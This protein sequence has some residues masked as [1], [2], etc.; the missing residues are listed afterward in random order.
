MRIVPGEQ[1]MPYLTDGILDI[2]EAQFGQ[3]AIQMFPATIDVIHG[4]QFYRGMMT[5]DQ[6]GLPDMMLENTSVKRPEYLA[7]G[8]DRRNAKRQEAAQ[9]CNKQHERRKS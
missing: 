1:L 2:A 7:K 6:D 9:V 4:D 8:A 5:I 3:N